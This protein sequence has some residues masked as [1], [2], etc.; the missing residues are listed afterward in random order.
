MAYKPGDKIEVKLDDETLSG[1]FVPSSESREDILILKLDSGYNLVMKKNRIKSVS[2]IE[3]SKPSKKKIST[4]QQ[5]SSLPKITL[6]HTG[7]TIAARVDYKLGAV[8][9]GFITAEELLSL[10]PEI[11]RLA[12]VS[13]RMVSNIASE[14]MRFGHYNMVLEAIKEEIANGT[15]AIIIPHG[16][17][18]LHYTAAALAFGLDNLST[19]ILLVG[20][21]RSSDRGSSDAY[22]NLM[23]AVY[24]ATAADFGGVGICMHYSPSDDICSVIPA[25]NSRKMHTSRR[26]AFRPIGRKPYALVNW[27]DKEIKII[28]QNYP[29]KSRQTSV[30]IKKF[31]EG[32]KIG[33]LKAHPNM[34]ASEVAAYNNFDGLVIEG[35][36]LGHF[37]NVKAD[38]L[39]AENNR[40]FLAV[41]KLVNS[42]AIVFVSPQTI[43]G[44]IQ[45]NV[46][47]PLR[48]IREIGVLGHLSDM[49][50]ETAFIKMAYLLSNYTKDEAR[51]MMEKN[52]KG[53]ISPRLEPEEFLS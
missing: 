20:S 14:E 19:P 52:L 22:P 16:T 33:F 48:R 37:P 40:I 38:G 26:D 7:G 15:E 25:F 21:Q 43:Y 18:T 50:S 1:T 46:Y 11:G 8:L 17:D 23:S 29:K 35:T 51:E 42:G 47:T 32:L 53:E 6:L 36:G 41:E 2:L 12:N 4:I 24:F 39:T 10:Y 49:T 44:R 3:K 45:M 27:L 28:S 34:Y 13:C 30:L 5:N 9:S 31:D